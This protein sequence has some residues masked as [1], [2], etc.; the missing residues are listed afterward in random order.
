MSTTSV[1]FHEKTSSQ[2]LNRY[3]IACLDWE[4]ALAFATEAQ[5]HVQNSIVVDALVFSA[6]V[7]YY[8]PFS[9]NERKK[10]AAAKSQLR[11]ED[12]PPLT[13]DEQEIHDTCKILRNQA[14]AHSEFEFNPTWLNPKNGVISSRPFSIHSQRFNIS[15]FIKLVNIF[16]LACHNK[17]AD[18]VLEKRY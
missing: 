14:L 15:S 5:K 9:S 2:E 7:C 17:R 12:F 1:T 6:I 10:N 11:I 16:Q 4:N 3:S 18:L 8:R 13:V